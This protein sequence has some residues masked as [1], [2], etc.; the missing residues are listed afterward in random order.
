MTKR[1]V[2]T[3]KPPVTSNVRYVNSM[4]K[5]P[6]PISCS[7]PRNLRCLAG[8][9]AILLVASSLVSASEGAGASSTY[10]PAH[11]DLSG[12][13]VYQP[14]HRLIGVLRI[15]GTPLDGLVGKLN[16]A[17][18]GM[19]GQIRL[20]AYLINTS[21]GMAGL[22]T[23]L[24]DIG[25]M[26]HKTWHTS[27]VAFEKVY[28]YPP[29][30]IKFASGSYDDP[31]GTTPGLMFIVNKKNPLNGLTLE[32]IDGIFGTQR[33]GGWEGSKWTTA[34]ARGPEKNIRTWGQLGLTGEWA[35]QAIKPYGSD[36]T[37]SNWNDLIQQE[38]FKGGTKWNPAFNENNRAD[39]ALK[40]KGKNADQ[41]I[42]EGV[43]NDPYAIGF[44]FQRV[45]NKMKADV[46]VLPLAAKAGGPY[47]APSA[48][49]FFDGSYPMRNGAYFYLNRVPGQPLSLRE[50][51]FVRFVLSREGQQII[52]DDRLFI[53]LN[54]E[55]IKAELKKLE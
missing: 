23:G 26:G 1:V 9:F 45:I 6:V 40:A 30:E 20:H 15:Y 52:A 5:M 12:L 47:V 21:Q 28:G 24:A 43:L 36:I 29:L 38:C 34:A 4:K 13:P 44:M 41:R 51:E 49:T 3:L 37:I 2:R 50:K 48:Q 19:H 7:I 42:I 35:N 53:P 55:Q 17:F 31:A 39:I 54:A 14:E 25:L 11:Y 18:R 33:T 46:K 22:T 16:T 27:R 10:Q 32:Q 8:F